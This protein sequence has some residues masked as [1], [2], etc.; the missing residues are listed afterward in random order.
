MKILYFYVH[1]SHFFTFFYARLIYLLWGEAVLIGLGISTWNLFEA[2][3][4]GR[5]ETELHF[6]HIRFLYDM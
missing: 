6:T 3:G 4:N 5:N 2:A 1:P